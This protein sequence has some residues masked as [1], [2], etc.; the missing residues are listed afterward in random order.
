MHFMTRW[1][2][3][4][5]PSLRSECARR[6]REVSSVRCRSPSCIFYNELSKPLYRTS[7]GTPTLVGFHH[8]RFRNHNHSHHFN[9]PLPFTWWE[10]HM[11][12]FHTA[13]F[14]LTAMNL[15]EVGND[16]SSCPWA[17]F[18]RSRG[19]AV[20]S[21]DSHTNPI[22]MPSLFIHTLKDQMGYWTGQK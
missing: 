3:N 16:I 2:I 18:L 22:E 7:Q 10:L 19:A 1:C 13:Y 9:N 20:T 14:K 15:P 6:R 5:R 8:Q 11:P 21:F 12:T 4:C 17:D